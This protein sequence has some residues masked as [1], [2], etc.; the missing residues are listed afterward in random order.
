MRLWSTVVKKPGM[1][2]ASSQR[3]LELL[4]AIGRR[5]LGRAS[6]ATLLQA[7][8]V[9]DERVDVSVGRAVDRRHQAPGLIAW[10][11]GDP[12]REV[13]R[14]VRRCAPAPSVVRAP[15]SVRSGPT[16]PAASVPLDGVAPGA[17][18][19]LEHELARA[20]PTRTPARAG[21]RSLAREPAFE[22]A[23]RLDDARR[24]AM[25]AC[26]D[27]AELGALA[28]GRCRRRRRVKRRW[29]GWPGIEVDL[30]GELRAPRS[31][32]SR[33][34]SRGAMSTARPT[35][36]WISLAVDDARA[37]V[38]HLP[39]TS[40]RP[41]T[42]MRNSSRCRLAQRARWSCTV[43]TASTPRIDDGTTTPADPDERVVVEPRRL[44]AAPTAPR[45]TANR[46]KPATMT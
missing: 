42:S 40:A 13:A 19:A 34:R 23:R 4:V 2:G 7:L 22:V 41:T 6:M 39:T 38:A 35:G 30:A 36:T 16:C 44:G 26:C 31:C 10:R 28:R 24:S 8:E 27:A 11:V 14:R 43:T 12:P 29:L 32:G 15:T 9:G 3:S 25:W 33:C 5:L 20:R 45:R 17:R 1:P 18:L 46:M 37:G 21:G